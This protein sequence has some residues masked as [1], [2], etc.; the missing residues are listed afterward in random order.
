MFLYRR[1]RRA[2][3][4]GGVPCAEG[5]I[6]LA[7]A[8]GRLYLKREPRHLLR[9]D[10]GAGTAR[11][12]PPCTVATAVLF[13]DPDPCHWAGVNCYCAL[14][15]DNRTK[16]TAISRTKTIRMAG[17]LLIRLRRAKRMV[18]GQ[19]CENPYSATH[20]KSKA[21]KLLPSGFYCIRGICLNESGG[22]FLPPRDAY[23]THGGLRPRGIR[24][25]TRR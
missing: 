6:P 25:R 16:A 22:S 19:P 24:S 5:Q 10:T 7:N 1:G 12:A 11:F 8:A 15:A 14:C 17:T 4:K 20:F 18:G 9:T 23:Y 3:E 21:R 2:G 13:F